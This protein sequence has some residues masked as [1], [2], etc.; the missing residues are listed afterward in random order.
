MVE[1]LHHPD[2]EQLREAL[3]DFRQRAQPAQAGSLI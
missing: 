1:A 2:Q 3:S